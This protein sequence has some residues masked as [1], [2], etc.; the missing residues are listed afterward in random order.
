MTNVAVVT[1]PP[2]ERRA[3]I[4][5]VAVEARRS[6]T[7]PWLWLGMAATSWFAFNTT[8]TTY[9][10]GGYHGLMASFSGVAAGLFLL[11]VNAGGRDHTIGGPVAPEAAVGADDRALGRLVGLWPAVGVAVLFAGAVFAVQRLEGG[12][13]I[14]DWPAGGNQALYSIVEML[15]PPILFV[16]AATAGVALGRASAHRAIVSV[17]GALVIVATGVAYW[18]WQW[19]PAV[20]FTLIQT[21]PIEV[22][23]GSDFSPQLAP[24]TWMLSAPDQYEPTWGRVIVHHWMAGWHLVYLVGLASVFAGLAIRGR[25]GRVAVITGT[26]VVVVAL[27]GAIVA[28]PAGIAGA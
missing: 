1:R 24:S 9:A 15:Q 8:A 17:A 13:R 19:R 20:W 11:A 10:G 6:L 12:M 14:A 28:T 5:L 27:I 21:Q 25:R 18:A 16:V 26:A 3:R 2:R 4:A 7:A 22:R 23:L